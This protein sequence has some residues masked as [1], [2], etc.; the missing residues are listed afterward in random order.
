MIG[1][2]GAGIIA[3]GITALRESAAQGAGEA[4]QFDVSCTSSVRLSPW[5]YRYSKSDYT[6]TGTNE[7]VEQTNKHDNLKITKTIPQEF[8]EKLRGIWN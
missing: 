7:Q 5:I 6:T 4:Y 2:G 1:L 3:L 8:K